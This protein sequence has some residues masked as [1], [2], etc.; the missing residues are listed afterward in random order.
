MTE[1]TH[2]FNQIVMHIEDTNDGEKLFR[3]IDG[4][5]RGI[6]TRVEIERPATLE[7]A[8]E[9][10]AAWEAPLTYHES[11]RRHSRR[12]TRN[13][14][15]RHHGH[16][17]RRSHSRN[18]RDDRGRYRRYVDRPSTSG[19]GDAMELGQRSRVSFKEPEGRHRRTQSRERPGRSQTPIRSALRRSASADRSRRDVGRRVETRECFKCGKVGH[20]AADCRQVN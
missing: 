1:Y 10:A 2:R 17:R 14:D 12:H 19:H 3:Y 11:D 7:R 18:R 15:R 16:R 20:L 13:S 6:R 9:L 8:I 5:N 4:L